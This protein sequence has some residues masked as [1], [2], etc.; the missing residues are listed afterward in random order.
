MHERLQQQLATFFDDSVK[1]I[2]EFPEP[3]KSLLHQ[4]DATYQEADANGLLSDSVSRSHNMQRRNLDEIAT[5]RENY[6]I[7][8]ILDHTSVLVLLLNSKGDIIWFNPALQDLTGYSIREVQSQA[9]WDIFISEEQQQAIKTVFH[10]LIAGKTPINFRSFWKTRD[11]RTRLVEWSNA[12]LLNQDSDAEYIVCTG[13]DNTEQRRAEYEREQILI[14]LQHRTNQLKTAAAVSGS[15]VSILDP[16]ELMKHTVNIIVDA[17]D[18]YYV[19]MF[20]VEDGDYAVLKAGS[21]EAGTAMI[22]QNHRLRVGGESMIGQCIAT[23]KA[24]IAL[25]VGQEAIRFD[26]PYLPLTR[27]ELALPLISRGVCFGALTVQSTK[28]AA[29]SEE[30]VAILQ[31][32]VDQVAGA[33]ENARLFE[34]AHR[35][36]EE[37]KQAQ[38]AL[39]ENRNLLSIIID[40]LPTFF[41]VKDLDGRFVQLNKWSLNDF[42]NDFAVDTVIGKTDFDFYP[43]ETAAQYRAEEKQV[44][45]TGKPIVNKEEYRVNLAGRR[46]W[47]LTTKAALRDASGKII[48]TVGAAQEITRQKEAELALREAH[49][50][51]EAR[52]RERTIQLEAANRELESFAYSVSHDLR[53]PLRAIDGFSQA[54]MEDYAGLLD[55]D[56]LDYLL[57]VRRASQR[58]GQLIDDLL[59]LSRLTRSEVRKEKVDL[60]SIAHEVADELQKMEPDRRAEFRIEDNLILYGDS[61]L[62]RIV[63]E[64]LLHNAWKFTAGERTA[65]IELGYTK[66]RGEYFIRDNGVGFDMTYVDKLFGAFQRLHTQDEFEGTGI[67][68]ATVRRIIHRH[69]GRIRAEGFVGR[70]ATFHFSL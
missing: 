51:L 41:H 34:E 37:R 53:A 67:G 15:V 5:D 33:I 26:N 23:S 45:E 9:F 68:L 28:E 29:Y 38:R 35:E 70:G 3:L 55:E 27:S 1:S 44:I 65:L 16:K 47:F 22:A 54:L 2:D 12:V 42:R 50:N 57:R 19:G 63:L 39:E 25:D 56:G 49:N 58:M 13:V 60:S 11:N 62:L 30:D 61:R 40:T 31:T 21:G 14:D 4:V 36:I 24:R 46:R 18:F 43:G 52:V 17:F 59:M 66:E 32:M 6:I 20:L 64:N 10:R 69:G 48:G 7:T 8:S